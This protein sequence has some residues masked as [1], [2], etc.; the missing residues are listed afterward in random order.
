MRQRQPKQARAHETTRAA[1]PARSRRGYLS[2]E[3]VLTLPILMIALL[4]LFEFGVLFYARS[5]L[6]E[7]SR[8]AARLATLRGAAQEDVEYEV[9]R[10]LSQ[11]LQRGM[12]IDYVPGVQSGDVVTVGIH[13]P[14][15]SAAPDLLWPIGYSLRGRELYAET[16]MVKE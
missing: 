5:G 13:V 14:M 7:A 1:G 6:V 8:A 9:R 4:G 2:T 15:T 16:S 11:P 12:W 3:L 10:I